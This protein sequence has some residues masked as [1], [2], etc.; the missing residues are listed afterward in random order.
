[1]YIN[2]IVKIQLMNNFPN[3]DVELIENGKHFL[4]N[5]DEVIKDKRFSSIPR[6][7]TGDV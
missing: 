6:Y 3:I 5:E 2:K 4:L 7:L 1:M